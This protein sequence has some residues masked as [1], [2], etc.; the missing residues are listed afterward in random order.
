M[1]LLAVR[2]K[3]A[4]IDECVHPRVLCI[5]GRSAPSVSARSFLGIR[6]VKRVEFSP[7]GVMYRNG[8]TSFVQKYLRMFP[9]RLPL[10]GYSAEDSCSDSYGAVHQPLWN[11]ASGAHT[12]SDRRG[13]PEE[14][15]E[16]LHRVSQ[17]VVVAVAPL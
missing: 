8:Q 13:A 6:V 1:E 10:Q 5:E 4:L 17:Q 2:K 11:R 16:C 9:K 14:S 15:P 12:G 7:A 3:H